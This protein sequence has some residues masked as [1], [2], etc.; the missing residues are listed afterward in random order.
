MLSLIRLLQNK[1]PPNYDLIIEVS[2]GELI[3]VIKHFRPSANETVKEVL[4]FEQLEQQPE[5]LFWTVETMLIKLEGLRKSC[6]S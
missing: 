4:L 2:G 1:L 6:K 3:L 5:L